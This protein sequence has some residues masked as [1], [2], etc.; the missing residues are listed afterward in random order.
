[1]AILLGKK[2]IVGELV[3]D[4]A[5]EAD[6]N[7]A[8]HLFSR[9]NRPSDRL[10][11]RGKGVWAMNIA[12]VMN[13]EEITDLLKRTTLGKVRCGRT[14][15]CEKAD[16]WPSPFTFQLVSDARFVACNQG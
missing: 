4:G 15:K 3:K 16:K 13:E 10:I 12:D 11:G 1:V 9:V 14:T 7:C 2:E 6:C 8:Q 5:R